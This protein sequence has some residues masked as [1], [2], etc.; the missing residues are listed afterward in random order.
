VK[1]IG[2]CKDDIELRNCYDLRRRLRWEE[3]STENKRIKYLKFVLPG[4]EQ[5][6][7]RKR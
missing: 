1:E 6:N 4:N 5:Y 7:T 2:L 3:N